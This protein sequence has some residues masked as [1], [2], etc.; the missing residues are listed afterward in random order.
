M[1]ETVAAV[2]DERE[3]KGMSVRSGTQPR[4][5]R[6]P[7]IASHAIAFITISCSREPLELTPSAR[8]SVFELMKK[9]SPEVVYRM[10]FIAAHL[11]LL[12]GLRG[13]IADVKILG[14]VKFEGL[15][16]WGTSFVRYSA[17]AGIVA[18]L[19]LPM[20]VAFHASGLA[21][22]GLAVILMGLYRDVTELVKMDA[23]GAGQ[24]PPLSDLIELRTDG[25]ILVCGVTLCLLIVLLSVAKNIV[26]LLSKNKKS[27]SRSEPSRS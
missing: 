7:F 20:R 3:I 26:S 10:A 13:T 9:C 15:N 4:T 25:K 14:E 6:H 16:Q 27:A 19:I 18:A 12:W 8:L 11:I 24:L 22:G 21:L 2:C 1:P 17:L 5:R 23:T